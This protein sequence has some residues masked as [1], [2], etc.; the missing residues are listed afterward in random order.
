MEIIGDVHG[1]LDKLSVLLRVSGL[2]DDDDHWSGGSRKV[3][4]T[5]DFADRGPYGIGVIRLIMRL[6]DEARQAGGQVNALLGNHDVLLLAA[7]RLGEQACGGPGGT[8]LEDWR[9]NGGVQ[10]DLEGLTDREIDWLSRLSAMAVEE[11][12]LLIHADSLFYKKYGDSM[13]EINQSIGSI[14]QNN[15]ASAWDRLLGDFSDRLAFWENPQNA[16]DFLAKFTGSRLIHG[17]TPVS[18]MNAGF[19]GTAPVVYANGLC[20]NVDAGLYMGGKGFI[21]STDAKL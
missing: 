21:Y 8:F 3:W 14:L 12:H 9:T 4:F 16:K 5:G 17:H 18:Y 2:V 19:D 10:S 1:Q 7:D 13:L 6:Q 20:I 11:D 15:V